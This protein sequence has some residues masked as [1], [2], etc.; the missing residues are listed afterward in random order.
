MIPFILF[1]AVVVSAVY[2]AG[3]VFVKNSDQISQLE[4]ENANW[5]R[6]DAN[7]RADQVRK[8]N[9]EYAHK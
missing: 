6:Y 5:R 1:T 3:A 7:V 4:R 8:R 9:S 2:Y